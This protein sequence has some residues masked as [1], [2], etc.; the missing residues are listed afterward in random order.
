MYPVESKSAFFTI[1]AIVHDVMVNGG[2]SD[3]LKLALA[4][5]VR[6]AHALHA[7]VRPMLFLH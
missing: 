7:L 4:G 6:A 1:D 5:P 2:M 3:Q